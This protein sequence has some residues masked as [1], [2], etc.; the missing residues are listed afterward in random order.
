MPVVGLVV[1]RAITDPAPGT[2][3]DGAPVVVYRR[4][5]ARA[6]Y[7]SEI[8]IVF[9]VRHF[10]LD[11]KDEIGMVGDSIVDTEAFVEF[12]VE[13]PDAVSGFGNSV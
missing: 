5:V 13:A 7:A 3:V 11:P 2:L 8:E 4:A 10:L 6:A 9:D 1:L 12:V